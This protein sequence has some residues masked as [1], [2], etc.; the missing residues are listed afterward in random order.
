MKKIL[1]RYEKHSKTHLRT[2]PFCGK[3]P[4][5][6]YSGNGYKVRCENMSCEVNPSTVFFGNIEDAIAVWNERKPG[7]TVGP[8]EVAIC[9]DIENESDL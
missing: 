3:T 4:K 2:C 5:V 9:E 6:L 7:M 8:I 1:E